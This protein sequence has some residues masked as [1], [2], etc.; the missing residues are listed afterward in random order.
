MGIVGYQQCIHTSYLHPGGQKWSDSAT[1]H[2]N[3]FLQANHEQI[4]VDDG[5]FICLSLN[6][7]TGRGLVC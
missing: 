6:S 5:Y 4:C 3:S 1:K 7:A 2:L